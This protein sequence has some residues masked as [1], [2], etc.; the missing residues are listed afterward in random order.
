MDANGG[1]VIDGYFAQ[2]PPKQQSRVDGG[3]VAFTSCLEERDE[4]WTQSSPLSLSRS[5]CEYTGFAV[6]FLPCFAIFVPSLTQQTSAKN[7]FYKNKLYGKKRPHTQ[8]SEWIGGRQLRHFHGAAAQSIL[9]IKIKD[10]NSVMK[11][12]LLLTCTLVVA[13][14]AWENGHDATVRLIRQDS[15]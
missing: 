15:R 12:S 5:V 10:E 7:V 1:E 8:R 6:L 4:E 13:A 11:F 9:K 14:R 2:P 3:R